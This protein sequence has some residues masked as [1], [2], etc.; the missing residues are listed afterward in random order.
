MV[1]NHLDPQFVQDFLSYN[2]DRVDPSPLR[3][4]LPG[5]VLLGNNRMAVNSMVRSRINYCGTCRDDYIVAVRDLYDLVN[6][7]RRS[8]SEPPIELRKFDPLGIAHILEL[9]L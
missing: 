3:R 4:L 9:K 1:H 8:T 7:L 6:E 5:V 2:L